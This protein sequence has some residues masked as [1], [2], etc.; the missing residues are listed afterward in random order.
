MHLTPSDPDISTLVKKIE[1]N[2]LDL[3]P[4]FQRGE[5]WGLQKKQRLIDSILRGWHIPPIH[6]IQVPNSS[7]QEVLDG[8][9]RLAAIR[10][11]VDG[12]FKFNAN[13]EPNNPQFKGIDGLSYDQLDI[14]TQAKVDDFTIRI[15]TI[16][17]YNAGEPGEL[18]YRLNQPTNL[19]SAEQRNAYFGEA[20]QQVK[21]LSDLMESLGYSNST[22]G[23]NNSRMA[24]DDILAKLLLSIEHQTLEKK[25][26]ATLVT[27]RYRDSKGFSCESIQIVK[28][29]LHVMIDPIDQELGRAKLNKSTLYSWLFF[30][31]TAMSE[32]SI[33][34]DILKSYLIYFESIKS[35]NK[36]IIVPAKMTSKTVTSL[37]AIF[38]DRASSRVADISSVKLRDIIL[39]SIFSTTPMSFEINSDTSNSLRDSMYY[40]S[41]GEFND[42]EKELLNIIKHISWGTS[43]ELF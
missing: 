31:C 40:L 2:R 15:I 29:A 6:V 21:D 7:K 23:F 38:N 17:D 18:F 41:S 24:Y 12:K 19:T 5:V 14:D 22:I 3:Q 1:K 42:Y 37:L 27:Q 35:S 16:S 30:I 8:Q 10:D 34:K 11:F 33:P 36:E 28:N 39:W 43:Y 32:K 20:R 4:N 13:F 26:T 9:Q 25:I